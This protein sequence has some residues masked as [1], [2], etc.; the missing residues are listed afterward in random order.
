MK[1]SPR[2]SASAD[3]R[4]RLLGLS[5][6]SESSRLA[7]S[8]SHCYD[9]RPSRFGA[10]GTMVSAD[11]RSLRFFSHSTSLRSRFVLRLSCME[12]FLP[13][14]SNPSHGH[15]YCCKYPCR[16]SLCGRSSAVHY[17]D[18]WPNNTDDSGEMLSSERC[19]GIGFWTPVSQIRH[20]VFHDGT[21]RCTYSMEN[22]LDHFVIKRNTDNHL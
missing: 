6:V 14:R 5:S 13:Q 9:I 8:D 17:T 1:P 15:H 7:Y 21:C 18:V 3:L 2:P 12:A 20:S 16:A 4:S 10:P 22:H 11:S 19:C